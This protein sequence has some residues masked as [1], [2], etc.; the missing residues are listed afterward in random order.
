MEDRRMNVPNQISA[1]YLKLQLARSIE[2]EG[3]MGCAFEAVEFKEDSL[4]IP[5]T[6]MGFQATDDIA[7]MEMWERSGRILSRLAEEQTAN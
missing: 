3:A 2:E 5:L 6:P 4:G 7:R 1:Y